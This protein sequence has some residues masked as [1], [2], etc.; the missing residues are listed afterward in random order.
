MAQARRILIGILIFAVV[1]CLGFAAG[2]Y[3]SRVQPPAKSPIV[4]EATPV[5]V[6]PE[7]VASNERVYKISPP[8]IGNDLITYS[9]QELAFKNSLY[10]KR[11]PKDQVNIASLQKGQ[12]VLLYD[13]DGKILEAMGEI[14]ALGE[15]LGDTEEQITLVISFTDPGITPEFMVSRGEIITGRD[16]NV[17][18]LPKSSVVND[19]GTAKLWEVQEN[20]AGTYQAH[21]VEAPIINIE[22]DYVVIS[23]MPYSSNLFILNPDAYL[24]EGMT[25]QTEKT[26]YS[27]PGATI[28]YEIKKRLNTIANDYAQMASNN[29]E[30]Q[31][32]LNNIGVKGGSCGL[33]PG[34]SQRFIDTIKMRSSAPIFNPPNMSLPGSQAR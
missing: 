1:V 26:L 7:T 34:A 16:Q 25:I 4:T 20:V 12:S 13:K 5:N 24:K 22:A 30:R 6:A 19:E 29:R 2:F 32:K 17:A 27:G 28:D 14:T 10:A 21:L 3:T 23:P 31:R 8:S 18:R 33:P 11:M 9:I 15:N